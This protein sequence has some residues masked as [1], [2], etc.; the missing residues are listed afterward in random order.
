MNIHT[1]IKKCQNG[2]KESFNELVK[3][4]YPFVLKFLMK[5]VCNKN[6][7]EDL[8][9]ET[10]IKIIKNIDN[11]DINGKASFNTY[12]ISIAKHTYIDYLRKNNKELQEIDIEKIPDKTDSYKKYFINENYNLM[13]EKI[14]NLPL[15]QKEAI[16]L[17]Y[18]EGY[19]LKEI[20][21]IQKVESKTVKSRLFEGRKKLKE[22]MKEVDINE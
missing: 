15:Y 17:K 13:L 18:I 22:N 14:E 9:Q 16:K 4:Y 10:F 3:F 7:T 11:F 12:L 19:T 5:L 6:I 21:K 1:L 2:N 20:A 8:V